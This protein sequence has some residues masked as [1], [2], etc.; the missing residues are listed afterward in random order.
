MGNQRPPRGPSLDRS[1]ED[2]VCFVCRISRD[3]LRSGRGIRKGFFSG[4]G[5]KTTKLFN[6]TL[7]PPLS[8]NLTFPAVDEVRSPHTF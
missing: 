8:N 6:G 4:C 2:F 5:Q 1:Q 3:V 7:D